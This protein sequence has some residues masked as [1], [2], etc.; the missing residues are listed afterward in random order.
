MDLPMSSLLNV[1]LDDY[2][3]YNI[4]EFKSALKSFLYANSFY[5]LDE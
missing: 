5:S 3:I 1:M 4:I 2:F